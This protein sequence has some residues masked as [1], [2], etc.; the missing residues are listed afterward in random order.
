MCASHGY[1]PRLFTMLENCVSA[2]RFRRCPAVWPPRLIHRASPLSRYH[3]RAYRL[4]CGLLGHQW[5]NSPVSQCNRWRVIIYN[6][7]TKKYDW[8][9]IHGTRSNARALERKFEDAKRKGDYVGPLERKTFEEVARLFLDD[10]RANNSRL[11]T[12]EEYQTELKLRLLPQPDPKLPPLGPRDMRNIKRGDMK[13]H[14]NALRNG[15]CT[16]SQVKAPRP[17]RWEGTR[18]S[19]C[20][21]LPAQQGECAQAG[22]DAPAEARRGALS[23]HVLAALDLRQLGTRKR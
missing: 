11:S 14:F 23:R 9:T 15:G 4:R 13:T 8:H 22:V 7:E 19:E 1:L 5:Q 6:R 10:R 16:V 3:S 18:L 20:E 21:R 2:F 12:L 17:R